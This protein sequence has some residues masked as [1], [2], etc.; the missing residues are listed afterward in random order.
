MK[1]T[2]ITAIILAVLLT[3]SLFPL[4]AFAATSDGLVVW[5]ESED[6]IGVYESV[7]DFVF[8]VG[9]STP[10]GTPTFRWY[11]CD[12]D[13]LPLELNDEG[14]I[15]YVGDGQALLM[16]GIP[17]ELM[18]QEL[19]YRCEVDDGVE[20]KWVD[21]KCVL[22]PM[23]IENDDEI[24]EEYIESF[25]ITKEPDKTLYNQGEA[26]DLSGIHYR[27]NYKDG[28]YTGSIIIEDLSWEPAYLYFEGPDTVTVRYGSFSDSFDVT[29]EEVPG[30]VPPPMDFDG[31]ETEEEVDLELIEEP[32]KTNYFEGEPI[33]LTGIKC[34][35]WTSMG[36]RDIT[37]PAEFGVDPQIATGM[38][39]QT[40]SVDY[41]GRSSVTYEIYVEMVNEI[42]DQEYETDLEMTK[43]PDKTEYTVGEPIDLTGMVCRLYTTLG[44]RDITDLEG[45]NFYPKTAEEPG[46][47]SIFVDYKGL[48]EFEFT[49]DVY[50][51]GPEGAPD[52]PF[53][54]I[55]EGAYYEQAVSW[56]AQTGVTDGN[57]KGQFMPFQLC[58]RGQVVT[59]LW[60]AMGSPEPENLWEP[61]D[62]VS[63]TDYFYK[64]VIWAVS[65]GITDGTSETTFSP[66]SQCR[67]SHIL[68]FLWRTLGRPG[69]TGAEKTNEWWADALA[70]AE[71]AG[72]LADTV[73]PEDGTL[74]VQGLC[75]RC[76]VITYLYR[77]MNMLNGPTRQ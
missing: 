16:H 60:R 37:D 77:A 47:Q 30:F 32:A 58:T 1:R 74:N 53:D 46:K 15:I 57:G 17:E 25:E 18:M 63:D 76:A 36:F 65:H 67:Y 51:R 26:V 40:I 35:L 23:G 43:A 68:T 42:F 45:I 72:L 13:G 56:A 14:K 48:V 21:F 10:R 22:L 6:Y 64:P 41:K 52:H 4:T 66:Y 73:D 50:P 61:F 75:P 62:D 20:C 49:V 31:D 70:W 28:S 38:G 7:G 24:N 9:Y 55:P 69:D 27:I 3:V 29:V 12:P 11:R 59:F 54:D 2:K 19:I 44:F 71:K 33:D 39:P 5:A 34:R 8:E